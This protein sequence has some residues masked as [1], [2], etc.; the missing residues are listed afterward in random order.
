MFRGAV[1]ELIV[2]FKAF[3]VTLPEVTV[4]DAVPCDA[5]R[6]AAMNACNWLGAM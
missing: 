5:I 4:I 2:K 6:F 3:V 1:F